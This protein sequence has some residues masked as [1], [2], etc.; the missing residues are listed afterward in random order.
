MSTS[1]VCSDSSVF[2]LICVLVRVIHVSLICVYMYVCV[3]CAYVC[4][5]MY[6]YIVKRL[7][8]ILD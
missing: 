5:Y 8:L 7:E 4:M 2:T 3:C 6:V 1:L